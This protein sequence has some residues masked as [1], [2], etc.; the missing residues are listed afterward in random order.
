MNKEQKELI[1]VIN[2]AYDELYVLDNI[3]WT[4][5]RKDLLKHNIK[6]EKNHRSFGDDWSSYHDNAKVSD[7]AKLFVVKHIAEA[8]INPNQFEMKDI[9]KIKKSIPLS[10]SLVANYK[11]KIIEAWKD[12]NIK[13]LANL[14]YVML[15]NYD[16]Y[17]EQ[18]QRRSE[19]A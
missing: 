19:V 4:P 11:D 8:I 7:C 14:D 3:T 9:I 12:Q 17:L 1:K 13:Y 5:Y 16:S 15:V 6:E 2:K 18:Q 10:V